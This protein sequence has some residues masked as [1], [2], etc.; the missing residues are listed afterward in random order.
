MSPTPSRQNHPPQDED[1]ELYSRE[2]SRPGSPMTQDIEFLGG[3]GGDGEGLYDID[4]EPS[5]F[6][7]EYLS[8]DLDQI[9][10]DCPYH[11]GWPSLADML[12]VRGP[13][14][15]QFFLFFSLYYF[16]LFLHLFLFFS[17]S[18]HQCT[19]LYTFVHFCALLS[20]SEHF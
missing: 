10:S 6:G 9:G 18:V 16:A 5:K 15:A 7:D 2:R 11:W 14:C 12:N 19:L 8:D 20:T 1:F 13:R 4:M 17:L 3:L